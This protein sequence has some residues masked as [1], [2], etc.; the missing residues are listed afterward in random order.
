MRKGMIFTFSL[1]LFFVLTGCNG[2]QMDRV[3]QTTH[4]AVENSLLPA[5]TVIGAFMISAWF[6]G[7]KIRTRKLV[8]LVSYE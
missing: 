7:G 8:S 1:F 3:G 5:L 4:P 2:V 6:A